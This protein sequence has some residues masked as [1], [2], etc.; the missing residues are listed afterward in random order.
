M[1]SASADVY[2]LIYSG[3]KDYADETGRL[4][5]LIRTAHPTALRILDVGCGTGEHARLLDRG[6][7]FEVDGLDV[8][9]AFVAMAQAKLPGRRVYQGD[10]TSFVVPGRY[11][12]ILCLFS[13]IG[14]VR[15]LA[16]VERTLVR[17]R[18]HL[19]EDGIVVVEPWYSP[20]EFTGGDVFVKSADADRLKVCRMSWSEVDGR[21]SRLHFE[22]LIGRPSGL[23]RASEL[24]ELGLFTQAEMVSCFERAGL[25]ADYD[26]HG[27]TDRG[28]YLAR[29]A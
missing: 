12:V 11:D 22:Y 20:D 9:E 2:D 5:E 27:L 13:S 7:G 1:F 19:T 15:T 29:A 17:F 6:H 28:L 21:L 23:E 4:A 18:D 14:Y 24:H 8:E 25:V 26:P 3:F 16:N 10:M